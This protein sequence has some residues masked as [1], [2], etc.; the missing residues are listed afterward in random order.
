MI[1][2]T[3]GRLSFRSGNPE[4]LEQ[5]NQ[6]IQGMVK[7]EE[8]RLERATRQAATLQQVQASTILLQDML[9][10]HHHTR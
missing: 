1:W 3:R 10:Q 4:D 6:L 8:E 7:K 2:Y 5:A 9:Q